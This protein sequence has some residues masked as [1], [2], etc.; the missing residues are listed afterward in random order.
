MTAS[1][2]VCLPVPAPAGVFVDQVINDHMLF[3][4]ESSEPAFKL[5][6][7]KRMMM[8]REGETSLHGSL[9][10][11]GGGTNASSSGAPGMEIL[12][13]RALLAGEL[14]HW[15]RTS[16]WQCGPRGQKARAVAAAGLS[17]TTVCASGASANRP[18]L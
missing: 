6:H 17:C 18:R 7:H 4:I 9:D 10:T 12:L 8:A 3:P 16:T 13:A 1:H 11:A 15:C 5:T 14:M 2:V